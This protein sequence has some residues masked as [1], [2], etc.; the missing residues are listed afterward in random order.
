SKTPQTVSSL[1]SFIDWVNG[2]SIPLVCNGA[3][4]ALEALGCSSARA[5]DAAAHIPALR[6]LADSG[7]LDWLLPIARV[8]DE[9]KQ[10][11]ALV[12]IFVYIANDFWKSG[13]HDKKV[14]NANSFLRRL[15]TPILSST[16]AGAVVKI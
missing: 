14:D 1:I 3:G 15:E 5:D 9:Q 6:I 4:C 2:F 13:E 10:M 8:F 11:A 7:G 12:D 16:K